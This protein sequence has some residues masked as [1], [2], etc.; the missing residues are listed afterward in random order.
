MQPV[1]LFNRLDLAPKS[2]ANCGEYRIVYSKTKFGDP[3]NTHRFFLIF[4]AA[5]PNPHPT[6]DIVGCQQVAALWS[7][8][9]SF[10]DDQAKQADERRLAGMKRALTSVVPQD[11]IPVRLAADFVSLDGAAAQVVVSSHVDL[12]GVPFAR[13]GDRHVAS[14]DAA[15]LVFD[16]SGAVVGKLPAER[17]DMDLTDASYERALKD[18][19]P[20]QRASPMKPGRYRV[21]FAAREDGGGRLGSISQWVQIPNLADGKL[22]LSSVFLLEKEEPKGEAAQGSADG[23]LSLRGAQVLRRF[24]NTQTL[25]V[26]L[27]VYN[28]ARDATGSTNLVT[29]AEIWRAGVRLASAAPETMAQSA[30]GAPPVAHTQSIKLTPFAPGDYEVRM[31]VT[32]RNANAT[33]SGRVGFSID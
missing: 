29:Q 22:T 28:P 5:L 14:V 27:F 25:Y 21:R 30:P 9:K 7:D 4:E 10:S 23:G 18:G 32:D 2:L 33:T 16:E 3:D 1:G 17:A 13:A 12:R 6:H 31:V 15:A 11:G 8:L 19:L 26:Q 20:Y 24:K